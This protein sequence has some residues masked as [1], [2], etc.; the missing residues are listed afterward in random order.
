M[1]D[2]RKPKFKV[3]QVVCVRPSTFEKLTH[4]ELEL[5]ADGEHDVWYYTSAVYQDNA[6]TNWWPE[7]RLRPLTA[8]EREGKP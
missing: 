1:S 2:K 8:K 5:R 6:L 7:S 3:G 4:M